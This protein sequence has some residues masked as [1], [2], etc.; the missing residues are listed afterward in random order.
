MLALVG[1]E[2]RQRIEL[3]WLRLPQ[4]RPFKQPLQS[5][6][7]VAGL[8]EGEHRQASR[9]FE[10][11]RIIEQGE[12]L[13]RR[14]RFAPNPR[15]LFPGRCI[16][17]GQQRMKERSLPVH[18]DAAAVTPIVLL[19]GIVAIRELQLRVIAGWLVRKDWWTTEIAD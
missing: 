18:L 10:E 13:Q 2:S 8:A 12:R 1:Q 3:G 9:G 4:Q 17:V 16:E 5:L 19:F 15:A 6:A 11:T 14:V 7:I